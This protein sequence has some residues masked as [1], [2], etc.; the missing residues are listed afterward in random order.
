[1]WIYHSVHSPP[2]GCILLVALVSQNIRKTENFKIC[3]FINE[4]HT[5]V[6]G[7]NDEFVCLHWYK[8]IQYIEILGLEK[9]GLFGPRRAKR[10]EAEW[11]VECPKC[12]DFESTHLEMAFSAWWGRKLVFQLRYTPPIGSSFQHPPN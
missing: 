11:R 9:S 7:Y 6:Q 5:Q 10:G 2:V 4:F 8:S 12:L 3:G 1:M